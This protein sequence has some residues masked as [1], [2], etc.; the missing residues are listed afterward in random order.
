[1]CLGYFPEEKLGNEVFVCLGSGLVSE[2]KVPRRSFAWNYFV[3][4]ES[5]I[6]CFC[7]FSSVEIFLVKFS[8]VEPDT[9]TRKGSQLQDISF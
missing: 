5:G 3:P 4:W 2:C 7:Y 9:N 8:I 6:S 1:M